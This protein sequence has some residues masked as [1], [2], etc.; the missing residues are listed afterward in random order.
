MSEDGYFEPMPG[1]KPLRYIEYT[2]QEWL[3]KA[4]NFAADHMATVDGVPSYRIH[5]SDPWTPYNDETAYLL[6]ATLKDELQK[7]CSDRFA[8]SRFDLDSLMMQLF[9]ATK[10]DSFIEAVRKTGWDSIDRLSYL[11]VALGWSAVDPD[12]A[13]CPL[14]PDEQYRYLYGLVWEIFAGVLQRRLLPDGF[15]QRPMPVLYGGQHIGKSSTVNAIFGGSA[16]PHPV[17]VCT[18]DRCG[19]RETLRPLFG[20][21]LGTEVCECDKVFSPTNGSSIKQLLTMQSWTGAD[22]FQSMVKEHPLRGLFIGTTNEASFLHSAD[23]SRVAIIFVKGQE[24]T[25]DRDSLKT[26]D[27]Y[28]YVTAPIHLDEHPE[29]VMQLYAQAY[30]QMGELKN[31]RFEHPWDEHLFTPVFKRVQEYDNDNAITLEPML[32][33]FT[34][35]VYDTLCAREDDDLV[36]DKGVRFS[37]AVETFKRGYPQAS[38]PD[39]VFAK[40]RELHKMLGFTNPERSKSHR[41]YVRFRA[42]GGREACA[43]ILGL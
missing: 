27:P 37:D 8:M 23:N 13:D 1:F 9:A 42:Y 18:N 31:G 28:S 38:I 11:P 21:C 26:T 20:K 5:V 25:P 41:D 43:R 12:D 29:Y 10:V 15:I 4:A 14:T 16:Y 33:S 19:Y 40:F 24:D 7:Y 22:K 6:R 2:N 34:R 17:V 36:L 30:V 35:H 39:T 32:R 3:A